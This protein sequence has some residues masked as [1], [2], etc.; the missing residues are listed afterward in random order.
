VAVAVVDVQVNSRGA[1]DQ[2]RNI[3]NASKQAQTGITGLTASIGKLAAGFS[4]IQAAKFV[5]AK[6]A[7]IESQAKSLEVLA[8]IPRAWHRT[9]KRTA[10]HVWDEW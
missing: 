5:F 8:A 7:E 1:V 10:A 3:N 9:A 4:A 2:L 6:T